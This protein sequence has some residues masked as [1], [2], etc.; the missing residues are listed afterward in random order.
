MTESEARRLRCDC[1]GFG[2]LEAWI[3]QQPWK[4]V[5]GVDRHR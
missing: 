2:G 4:V 1:G 5:P 3:A